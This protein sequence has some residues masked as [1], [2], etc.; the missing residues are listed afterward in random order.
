MILLLIKLRA[1]NLDDIY[2]DPV[3]WYEE[4]IFCCL[5]MSEELLGDKACSVSLSF[6]LKQLKCLHSECTVNTF[7]SGLVQFSFIYIVLNP[8]SSRLKVLEVK[9]SKNNT[10]NIQ[11]I[12]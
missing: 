5:I 11:T 9:Y 3:H 4:V 8:N 6:S 10:E 7:W 1:I 2:I 12:R